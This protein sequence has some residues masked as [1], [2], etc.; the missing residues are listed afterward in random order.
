M[1]VDNDINEEF[2]D[3]KESESESVHHIQHNGQRKSKG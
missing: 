3:T 2:E 1:K